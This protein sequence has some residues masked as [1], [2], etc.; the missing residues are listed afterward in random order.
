MKYIL[1]CY[2]P[3]A[4]PDCRQGFVN[5]LAEQQMITERIAHFIFEIGPGNIPEQAFDV[6]RAAI[7]DFIGVA[8]A[9][10]RE[11]TGN[12]IADCVSEMGGSPSSS[13]I[14]KGFRTAPPVGHP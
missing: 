4:E 12:I 14:G 3:A 8:I 7:M 6:A 2:W 1:S 11:E 9:G 10:S 13:V 5:A